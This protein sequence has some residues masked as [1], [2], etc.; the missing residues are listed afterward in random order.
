MDLKSFEFPPILNTSD[1]NIIADFFVPAL[2]ASVRYDRGVGFFSAGW[3]RVAAEGMAAFARNSG[4]ARWVTSPILS[5]AD[6]QALQLGE[7]ARYDEVLRRAL[8]RN[9]DDL[10]RALEH[11]TLSTLA[12]LVADGILD[13]KLAL[14]RNKL[15]HGEFHD[16]FGVFT[17][18]ESNQVSFN[19]SYN[20]SIQGTRNYESI[21]I[22][23][24][25]QPA[26]AP[27]VQADAERFERLWNNQDPNV[28]VFDL[29]NAAR[30]KILQLRTSKRPYGEL[31]EAS[32]LDSLNLPHPLRPYQWRGVRF[33]TGS[34]AALLADEMGLGKTVQVAVA[35]EILFRN[36]DLSRVLIVTPA[37]LKLNWHEELRKWTSDS[38]IQRVRGD[39]DDRQAYY[40]LPINI[41][42]A[43]YEEIRAD[44]MGFMNDVSFDVVVLDEAQRIKNPNSQTALAC[45]LLSRRRSWALTGTPVENR[46]DDLIS[47]FRFIKG[48]LLHE[49]LSKKEIHTRMQPHF[50]RRRKR[51]VMKELPPIIDQEIPLELEGQQR[52]AYLRAWDQRFATLKSQSQ[53]DL[54]AI[55]TKLKQLC[56][57]EPESEESTKLNALES[58]LDDLVAVD[59]KIIVFSQY[60][61]TLKWLSTKMRNISHELYHG[62][63]SQTE[64]S[65]VLERFRK[66]Q[67]PRI[68]LMSLRAGGV[69][70]NIQ[71]ASTV[72]LFDRW[73]NPALESQAVQRAHRFGRTRPLHVIRFI[74]LDTI[75]EQIAT[76]LKEKKVLFE[77][78][79]E[80]AE[81]AK[82]PPFDEPSL[83]LILEVPDSL[84][85]ANSL[86]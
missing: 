83:R 20:D 3:L 82:V 6:W 33:L 38:S 48:G 11:E 47:I 14:P 40:R 76:I 8:K 22:F 2:G 84:Y 23:C 51:E 75:E 18:A 15:E 81:S 69:G 52:E 10:E 49:A 43:S 21:K 56:N 39:A 12:W 65:K 72:V 7:A 74:V 26:F 46:L 58:I 55:I 27:L 25:W 31:V 80:T 62:T 29:P 28:C 37:S 64:R 13:F 45:K 54:L 41:L 32:P 86:E 68:L 4:R 77:S 17:D 9:L 16:K 70:L 50:L 35:L 60:V 44:I 71:E 36:G 34:D 24:S 63:L 1:A 30:E 5:E 53:A 19:G 66:E 73:W 42:I 67:G 61:E 79:V 59:D 78:Y 85:R 57:Y